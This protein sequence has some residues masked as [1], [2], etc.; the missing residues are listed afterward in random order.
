MINPIQLDVKKDQNLSF[1][2][3]QSQLPFKFSKS[4]VGTDEK[5]AELL[6]LP[7]RQREQPQK[8]SQKTL[9]RP[10]AAHWAQT[11]RK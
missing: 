7:S 8:S 11:R 3:V 4:T 1:A 5:C 10:V 9:K 2:T 6:Y